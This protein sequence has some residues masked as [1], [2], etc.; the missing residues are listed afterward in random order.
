[1]LRFCMTKLYHCSDEYF[2]EASND[3]VSVWEDECIDFD[4]L[5][6]DYFAGG[7]ATILEYSKV[8]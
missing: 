1:M 6:N 5:G 7:E 2:P 8:R 3:T 4:S